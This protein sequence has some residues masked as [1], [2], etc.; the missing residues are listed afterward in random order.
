MSY[1]YSDIRQW[2][3]GT[4]VARY[5]TITEAAQAIAG[6]RPGTSIKTIQNFIRVTLIG[7]AKK[8]YGYQWTADS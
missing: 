1:T 3:N 6:T 5:A 7:T 2:N 4:P 8:A